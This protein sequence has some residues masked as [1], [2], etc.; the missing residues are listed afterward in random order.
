MKTILF[1]PPLALFCVLGLTP[2]LQA[3]TDGPP[4]LPPG[5]LVQTRAPDFAEW[6]VTKKMGALED[7]TSNSNTVPATQAG[8]GPLST[9]DTVTKTQRIVRVVRLDTGKRPW[10][11]WCQGSQE[12]MIWPDGKSCAP[13]T[14]N[15]VVANPFFIDLSTADFQELGWVALKYYIGLKVYNGTKCIVYQTELNSRDDPGGAPTTVKKIAYVDFKSRL[16]IAVQSGDDVYLYQWNQPPQDMLSY[17]PM[18]LALIDVGL[19]VQ[20]QMAQKAVSPY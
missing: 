5:P 17:P 15:L 14:Q 10:T 20:H 16:P 9:Q 1:G 11:I 13:L 12:F 7:T 2:A 4:P 19:K 8:A 18:V 6:V 3:Q